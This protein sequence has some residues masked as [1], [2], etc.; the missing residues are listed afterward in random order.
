MLTN[1]MESELE[2]NGFKEFIYFYIPKPA[3]TDAQIIDA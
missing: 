1:M 3:T 2:D